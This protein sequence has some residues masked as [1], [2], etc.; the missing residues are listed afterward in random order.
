[1]GLFA[2]P[3]SNLAVASLLIEKCHMFLR[4]SENFVDQ[5]VK[6]EI[7]NGNKLQ[8]PLSNVN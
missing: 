6:E 2:E 5:K 8:A 4:F 1:M 3:S 7:E